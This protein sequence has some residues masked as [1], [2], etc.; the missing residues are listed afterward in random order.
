VL[1]GGDGVFNYSAPL[2]PNPIFR[3]TTSVRKCNLRTQL[4]VE[5]YGYSLIRFVA[6]NP[7]AWALHCH[8]SWHMEAGLLMTILSGAGKLDTMVT[9]APTAWSGLC[10]V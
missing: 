10:G 8:I 7:G 5:G 3:D 9:Q 2:D 6:D 1:A 4:I